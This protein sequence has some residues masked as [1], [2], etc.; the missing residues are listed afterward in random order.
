MIDKKIICNYLKDRLGVDP[1]KD[2]YDAI[3]NKEELIL[4]I[5]ADIPL[6][7]EWTVILTGTCWDG[8][9]D[10]AESWVM[11]NINELHTVNIDK[12]ILN[13]SWREIE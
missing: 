6:E 12:T 2:L 4:C 11:S 8:S 9:S 13:P 5:E 3:P 10:G 1:T 7:W